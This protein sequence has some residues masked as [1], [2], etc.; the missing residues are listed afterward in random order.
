MY[1]S[2][3]GVIMLLI[4]AVLYGAKYIA[5]VSGGVEHTQWSTEEFALQ[6][7]F[8]PVPMSVFIYLSAL[9]GVLYFIWG[10]WDLWKDSQK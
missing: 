2:L 1:K 10:S 3:I 8:V 5:A 4:S 7:S 9:I 6:L